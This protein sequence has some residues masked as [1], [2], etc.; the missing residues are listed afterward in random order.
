[1]RVGGVVA[2]AGMA[3]FN[4]A[5]LYDSTRRFCKFCLPPRRSF[6]RSLSS[7]TIEAFSRMP[8]DGELPDAAGGR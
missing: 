7:S 3:T 8:S 6:G 5:V 2:I 1:M 4:A